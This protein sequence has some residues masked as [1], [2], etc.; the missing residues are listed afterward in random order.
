M[1]LFLDACRASWVSSRIFLIQCRI[2]RFQNSAFFFYTRCFETNLKNNNYAFHFHY[3]TKLLFFL[4]CC[5]FISGFPPH[6]VCW[7]PVLCRYILGTKV[8]FLLYF[9]HLIEA[10]F[11]IFADFHSNVKTNASSV[12]ASAMW[13]PP[14]GDFRSRR[15]NDSWLRCLSETSDVKWAT[16]VTG[17]GMKQSR[18]PVNCHRGKCCHAATC[19]SGF[20]K[21]SN[22]HARLH[23]HEEQRRWRRKKKN[24][25]CSSSNKWS[26]NKYSPLQQSLVCL[27]SGDCSLLHGW[28][29]GL[30]LLGSETFHDANPFPRK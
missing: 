25:T 24:C 14:A 21:N 18:A 20:D 15:A 1:L 16:T 30:I 22:S 10:T 13:K 19:S 5:R 23:R 29:F 6:L 4:L 17:V 11:Q 28:I 9:H 8:A 27:W 7:I 12:H 2:Y 3:S 26:P